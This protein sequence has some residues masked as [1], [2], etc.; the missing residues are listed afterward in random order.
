M[1]PL[2][3][4]PVMSH[5]TGVEVRG[6]PEEVQMQTS[7][8]GLSF[9]VFHFSFHTASGSAIHTIVGRYSELDKRYAGLP[10]KLGNRTAKFPGKQRLKTDVPL[11]ARELREFF[12][13]CLRA[14]WDCLDDQAS[15]RPPDEMAGVIQLDPTQL[16][17][18]LDPMEPEPELDMMEPEPELEAALPDPEPELGS[19]VHQ[20]DSDLGAPAMQ[21]V[22]LGAADRAAANE[23]V[24]Q[25]K[26]Q[27]H[28]THEWWWHEADEAASQVHVPYSAHECKKLDRMQVSERSLSDTHC[29]CG[30]RG[31]SYRDTL[32]AG[33]SC[34]TSQEWCSSGGATAQPRCRVGFEKHA[35]TWWS[36][37]SRLH[38]TCS[39]ARFR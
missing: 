22:Q 32:V 37:H 31:A 23:L 9:A 11:R 34:G 6:G 38:T 8:K 3:G 10:R 14:G 16:D 28:D 36:G 39:A 17:P 20:L 30:R 1:T 7:E 5:D 27:W 29:V 2:R 21:A 24:E 19:G 4:A 15:R 18:D 33:P 25:H 35:M 13:S 26:K 12:D